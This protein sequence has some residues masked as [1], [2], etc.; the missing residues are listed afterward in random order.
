M[1]IKSKYLYF[2]ISI[3]IVKS[4]FAQLVVNTGKFRNQFFVGAGYHDSFGSI[5][6]GLNHT[7]YF[8]IIKKEIT[9][10]L[11]FSS[12]L[13]ANYYTRFVFRK[14]FQLDCYKKNDFKLPL[15]IITSSVRKHFH[16][17]SIHD[18]ITDISLLPGL[19]KQKFTIASEISVKV[20]WR[21]KTKTDSLY[22][23]QSNIN[24]NSHFHRVNISVGIILAYNVSHFSF[25][26]RS[27]FQQISDWEINKYPFY[28][29]G[30]MSYSLNFK[31]T[32]KN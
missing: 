3:F 22:Y 19:Y 6:Y 20:L 15:S 32:P 25:I 14:G 17:F 9:G 5:A 27:G 31:K 18:I 16:L 8:K 21:H 29:F 28:A 1:K 26:L 12:P 7:K 23:Q 13:S 2:I 11:D 30:Y 4:S 10:I 24:P